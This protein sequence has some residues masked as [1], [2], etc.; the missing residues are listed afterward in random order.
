[1]LGGADKIR[2]RM[3]VR[4]PHTLDGMAYM[5]TATFNESGADMD[6]SKDYRA[7]LWMQENIQGSPVI[8]EGHTT[9]YRWGN[10]FTINTGL[11]SVVGWNWH[12]RQQRALTPENW[13]TD[14]VQAIADFY[15]T[16]NRETTVEFLQKYNV[17]YIVVG[18]MEKVLYPMDGLVKFDVWEGDLWNAVYQDGDTVIYE[19]RR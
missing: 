14:R 6:L 18:V 1:L 9:E 2:D 3:S 11:P 7:I 16:F 12:Q 19:V 17:S 4:A 15:S 5:Q 10:R 13:V 8:V